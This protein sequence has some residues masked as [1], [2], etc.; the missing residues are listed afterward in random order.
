[1][2]PEAKAGYAAPTA[3]VPRTLFQHAHEDG[4]AE[5]PANIFLGQGEV[6]IH[7]PDNWN[8]LDALRLW[9][10]GG[11]TDVGQTVNVTINI[12]TADEVFNTHTQTVN[13]IAVPI[14][15]NEYEIE[16]LTAAFA[17][18]LANLAANDMMWIIVAHASGDENIY[19]VG[20]E[21]QET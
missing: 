20:A 21:A 17:A 11:A 6:F 16:D 8:G 10:V 2:C 15:L 7:F 1:M 9:F 12:A 18:V 5:F 3:R 4:S 13:A 14:V 19:L